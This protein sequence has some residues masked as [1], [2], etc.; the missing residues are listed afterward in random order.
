M[1]RSSR[2][3]F[4]VIGLCLLISAGIGVGL[5]F[6]YRQTLPETQDLVTG[7]IYFLEENGGRFPASEAEFRSADF[8]E[9]L[10]NGGLIVHS[11]PGTRYREKTFGIPI[12]DLGLFEIA[13]GVNLE[14][15]TVDEHS[16][17]RGKDMHE[18]SLVSWPSSGRAGRGYTILLMGIAEK[19]REREPRSAA[20]G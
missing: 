12:R 19:I 10:P 7:L 2:G 20:S 1:E 14:E 8:I 16:V 17:P 13:W 6:R 9:T 15:L 3:A 4:L 11:R 5:Y 18:I